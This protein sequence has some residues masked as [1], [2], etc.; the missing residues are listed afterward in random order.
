MIL[1]LQMLFSKDKFPLWKR[2]GLMKLAVN[3]AAS[4]PS[5]VISILLLDKD[6]IPES[7]TAFSVLLYGL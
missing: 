6:F 5:I 1:L 2:R 4:I 7:L 3:C